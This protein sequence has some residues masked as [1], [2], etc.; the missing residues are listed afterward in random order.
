V[1]AAHAPH[2]APATRVDPRTL[3]LA[4]NVRRT[5]VLDT[6]FK[7]DVAARGVRQPIEVRHDPLGQLLVVTGQ[8]R[9]L[10]ALEAGLDEVPV[11]L[12]DDIADEADRI[13]EQLAE[14]HHRAGITAADDATA[15]KQ[16]TLFGLSPAQIAKRTARPKDEV[17]A[18]LALA[19]ASEATRTALAAV[20]LVTAAKIAEFDGDEQTVTRLTALA[21]DEPQRL[22]HEIEWARRRATERAA[23]DARR[24]ELV[25][26]G[27]NVLDEAPR[28]GVAGATAAWLSDFT[29][30]PKADGTATPI[31]PAAHQMT[32]PGHAV[33]LP[34][35]DLLSDGSV[36]VREHF[37]CLDWQTHGHFKRSAR[38][39]ATATSGPKPEEA[40][41]ERRRV[42]A[43][44]KASD[45]AQQV[46]RQFLAQVLQRPQ[47]PKDTVEH[48]AVMITAFGR[49]LGEYSVRQILDE[50]WPADDRHPE[51]GGVHSHRALLA[52]AFALGE[53]GLPRDFW[54]QPTTDGWGATKTKAKGVLHLERLVQWGYGLADVESTWLTPATTTEEG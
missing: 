35:A 18:A 20:D 44:N 54:R 26:Q 43:N 6:E 30:Q 53:W 48:A 33:H 32:C 38:N 16:L 46:R 7:R 50:V 5:V 41:A 10:A 29:D 11:V 8:R 36:L 1:N 27:V 31:D 4:E 15:V 17:H 2:V 19:D 23:I 13:V 52:Q 45:A 22:D 51:R 25:A 47:L 24:A 21:A 28:T 39:T 9:T 14:N 34:A 12:V 40:T 49:F 3:V 42:V 37:Y